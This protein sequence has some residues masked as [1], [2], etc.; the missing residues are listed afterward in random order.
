MKIK[1]KF[2]RGLA[3]K[4]VLSIFVSIGIIFVGIFYYTQRI[5]RDIVTK[6]LKTNA[7]YLTISTVSKIEKVLS[8][9]QRVPDNLVRLVEHNTMD[10]KQINQVVRLMVDHNPEILGACLAFRPYYGGP[11]KKFNAYYY[12]RKDGKVE[13]KNLGGEQYDYFYMDWYQIPK[14]LGRA[15]W[16]E[17]YFDAGGADAVIST[18][19]V[20]VFY[21]TAGQKE[22]VGILTIDISMDWLQGYVNAIKVYDT[23][24]GFM[25]SKTGVIVTHPNKD[26]IMNETIFSIADE[27]KST[28]L[29]NIGRSMINGETSFA[30]IEYRNARTGKLSWIAYAPIGFNGWS[31]GIVFP[32]DEF[33]TD[34]TRLSRALMGMGFGSGAILILITILIASSITRPLRKLTKVTEAFAGG[35]FGVE[36]PDIKSRDEI[37]RLNS[38]FRSMQ[39]KLAQTIGDLREASGQL[40]ESNEKLEEYSRSLEEK[41]EERTAELSSKNKELDAA[42]HNIRTLN[43]IGKK[44]TST[45]VIDSIQDMVYEH[46]N[47]LMDATSFLI[48]VHNEA[49]HRLDCKLS[50]EKGVKLP[51]FEIP[52]SEEN[53]FAVWCVK[54]A[55]PIFM[56]DIDTEY[57]RYVPFRAKPKA[58]ES[59]SSLIYLP[60]MIED[61]IVGV[62]SAQSFRK[63]AYTQYQYDMLLNLANFVAI[64]F[65]NAFA[66]EKINKANNELKAAQTQLIQAEKMASLGQ[67]TAG[68][69]HEIKNPL[70]F[71]NNF[72]EL[73][74]ELA[75]EVIEEI[76]KLPDSVDPKD[77]EYVIGIVQDIQSNAK[78]INEHGKRA[79]SIIRGMLLHS[80]GKSGEMQETDL[81]ALL[82]EYVALGY[83]G[84]RA[85]D[86]TFNIRIESDYDP[87]IGKIRVVP[88]DISRVFLNLVNN[89]CYSTVQKK[90]ELKDSYFPILTVSTKRTEDSVIIRVRDNGKGIPPAIVERIFNPFFTTKPAGSGTGLGLSIS[91][92][93][94]VQEHKGEIK[95]ESV[96]GEWAEFT[97]TLPV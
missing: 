16:S 54:H 37:G 51:P 96:E 55:T 81:N 27:Q 90:A 40:R 19:S 87:S 29:H 68:I 75:A 74:I 95:V 6:N 21:T 26:F 84:L 14:E 35:E 3:F 97:I 61:R 17:P 49:E 93:I 72:S 82:A 53:R 76:E 44:I 63:N 7:E 73:S 58:G 62:I 89:A 42:F 38:A 45:L 60:M 50:M 18:Y 91:Y 31:L 20:P 65:D 57:I 43:E 36:L 59:V 70:N 13:Y 11:S 92:D 28:A 1:L 88:Q 33:L 52:L 80:R 67:L 39:G 47:S 12:F 8:S 78:K 30:E 48:M 2:R 32:V 9:I 23:G 79:D 5:T 56:N 15:M 24:Y 94:V 22:F 71:V 66:Y 69:A 34:A 10:E 46:V 85:S 4:M 25:I 41:V 86:N 64:A 83:H 77:R